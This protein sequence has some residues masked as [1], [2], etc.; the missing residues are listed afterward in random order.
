MR[1]LGAPVFTALVVA[2]FGSSNSLAY[3]S[4]VDPSRWAIIGEANQLVDTLLSGEINDDVLTKLNNELADLK[5][6]CDTV[7]AL[8]NPPCQLPKPNVS[9]ENT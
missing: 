8:Q 7:P 2:G 3:A 6:Q 5:K 4:E 1:M 9:N